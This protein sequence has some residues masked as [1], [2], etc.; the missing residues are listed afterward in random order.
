MVPWVRMAKGKTNPRLEDIAA[1]SGVSA[2]TVSR[3]L[4]RSGSVSNELVTKVN[5][6]LREL[7]FSHSTKGFI[8][9]VIPDFSSMTVT[10][11]IV[12]VYSEAEKLGFTVVP[13]HMGNSKEATERNFQLL[14]M[15]GFDALI[16]LKDRVNPEELREQYQLG[17][18]PIV[19]VNHRVD[20][21]NIHCIDI[22][23]DIA[24][25][26]AAKYLISL[27]HRTIAYLSAPL[28]ISVAV[29]RRRGIEKALNEAGQSLIFRQAEPS[30]ESGFQMTGSLLND[31]QSEKPTAIIAFDDLVAVGCLNALNAYGRIVPDEISLIGFDDLFITRYTCPTLTTVHQP[32]HRMGQ[33]AVTKID[34]ILAGKDTDLGG[35]TILEC[36]L[37]V[38]ESTGPAPI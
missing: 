25:Y 20:L 24:M 19:M 32:W 37:T 3:V 21:P 27:G 30:I 10:D 5:Q 1:H 28:D 23:R 13:L 38:R 35:L 8:A 31:S 34:N 16:I 26:K 2:A 9:M 4:S 18:I 11:K 36:P 7:G 22:D 17:A 12:G 15:L 6:S 14:R 29:D 33:L